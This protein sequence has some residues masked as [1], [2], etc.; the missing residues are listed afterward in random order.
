MFQAHEIISQ[1]VRSLRQLDG[2]LEK[3]AQSAQAR[4][5]D[6]GAFMGLRLAPDQFPFE[7]QVQIACDAVRVGVARITGAEAPG[8][9][10][11]EKTLAE[12]RARVAFTIDAVAQ[13]P[14]SRFD[15]FEARKFTTPRWNGKTMNGHDYLLEHMIPNFHFHLVTVYA[16][17]R[18]AGVPLGKAD[19]LGTLTMTAP[20]G[21]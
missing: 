5:F 13:V 8:V 19:Y 18:H 7:R 16:L 20:A 6:L 15:G 12:L 3:A 14:A 9:P 4:G 11:T 21:A 10:D 1:M 17:L 2:W